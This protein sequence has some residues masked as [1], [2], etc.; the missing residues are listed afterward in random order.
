MSSKSVL[1]RDPFSSFHHTR[2]SARA[3]QAKVDPGPPVGSPG[4]EAL[5]PPPSAPAARSAQRPSPRARPAA[6]RVRELVI[7]TG[8]VPRR[9]ARAEAAPKPARGADEAT[10]ARLENRLEKALAE[11]APSPRASAARSAARREVPIERGAE[12]DERIEELLA[13]AERGARGIAA[14]G[15]ISGEAMTQ[16]GLVRRL[17]ELADGVRELGSLGNL[18]GLWRELAGREAG[19]AAGAGAAVDGAFAARVEPIVDFLYESYWRVET[20]GLEQVPATGPALVVANHAGLL[21]YDGLMIARAIR[22]ASAT[23]REVRFLV[24]D[25]AWDF[26][27]IGPLTARLGGL[28]ASQESAER[29]LVQGGVVIA[30]P[31]GVQGMTKSYRDRYQ[32]EDFGRGGFVAVAIRHKATLVPCAVIG[33]EEIHPIV[34]RFDRLGKLVGLPTLPIT[35]TLPLLGPLG[36]V[37]LP[38]K[39]RIQFGAPTATAK[40]KG[41][42]ADDYLAVTRIRDELRATIQR[43]LDATRE[44]HRSR[45]FG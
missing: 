30:F 39:W 34:T 38:S 35:P 36:L 32:L 5:A 10:F 44:T 1:G 37:P 9:G 3:P 26:P 7:D 33:S 2:A 8:E 24:D 28:R 29:V 41:K 27:V 12:I 43:A 25:T 14:S 17:V 4:A 19:D 15:G 40:R 21:P 23:G 16:V 45:F 42:G 20:S 13:A 11:S 31:E 22:G 6:R 18:R